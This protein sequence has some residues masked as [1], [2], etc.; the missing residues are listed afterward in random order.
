MAEGDA[1]A[2]AKG[3]TSVGGGAAEGA[4]GAGAAGKGASEEEVEAPALEAVVIVGTIAGAGGVGEDVS[5]A[6][7]I[8]VPIVAP[9][10][11]VAGPDQASP[12]TRRPHHVDPDEARP[13][14]Q[15]VEVT[16]KRSPEPDGGADSAAADPAKPTTAAGPPDVEGGA[17]KS[18]Y[19]V[20]SDAEYVVKKRPD[21]VLYEVSTTYGV[22]ASRESWLADEAVA[23]TVPVTVRLPLLDL[24]LMYTS[25]RAQM[26]ADHGG[27]V[28]EG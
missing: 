7:A 23:R 27:P 11:D 9:G 26:K 6:I 12:S 1:V 19:A 2:A 22:W 24:P 28:E 14:M 3:A 17:A 13:M 16:V 18:G 5:V 15:R 25:M 21:S 20:L 10:M 4:E 8:P